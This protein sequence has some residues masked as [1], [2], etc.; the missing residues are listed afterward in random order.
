MSTGLTGSDRLPPW[1]EAS[2]PPPP[3]HPV[4][5]TSKGSD[6]RISSSYHTHMHARKHTHTHSHTN[7]RTPI[8][9]SQTCSPTQTHTHHATVY[10]CQLLAV[11]Q[12]SG[13]LPHVCLRRDDTLLPVSLL[14]TQHCGRRP[15]KENKGR[16]E[17]KKGQWRRNSLIN[18]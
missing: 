14:L 9:N 7:L 6:S 5:V 11:S 15:M 17:G 12:T 3:R 16:K 2:A 18:L 8:H 13:P 10:R 1:E 4:T